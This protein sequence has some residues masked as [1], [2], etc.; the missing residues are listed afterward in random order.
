MQITCPHCTTSYAVDPANF[1]ASGRMVRCARCQETWLARPE[2]M[3]LADQTHNHAYAEQ[4]AGRNGQASWDRQPQDDRWQDQNSP[5]IE[6]PPLSGDW[7]I[8]EDD[9]IGSGVA[10]N[11]GW[12]D[13]PA[14]RK[15]RGKWFSR[16]GGRAFSFKGA[17]SRPAAMIPLRAKLPS[18]FTK[19]ISLPRACAVMGAMVFALVIWRNEVVRL[20]P[21]TATFFKMAG[22]RVNLRGL[23]F[24]DVKITTETVNGSPVLVIEGAIADITRKPV[25]LPRLRFIVRDAQGSDIYAWNSV[26]EQPVLNPGEK[27]LFKSRLA[28]PPAEGREIV[29][30]FLQRRDI[31]AGGV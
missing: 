3:A 27:V 25:E 19:K 18:Q 16:F 1:S 28:S 7:D 9:K 10:S 6:S 5:H 29:V 11:D 20:I 14:P 26:L 13:E 22:L 21:Q 8:S 2:G 12:A 30:R 23:S 4:T 17:R 24:E 31:V 15:P